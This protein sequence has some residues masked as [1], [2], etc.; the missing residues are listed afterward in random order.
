MLQA[1]AGAKLITPIF[2]DNTK[3]RQAQTTD[4]KEYQHRYSTI[5]QSLA[6]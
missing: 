3:Q 6:L 2:Q 5:Y 1:I 4:W